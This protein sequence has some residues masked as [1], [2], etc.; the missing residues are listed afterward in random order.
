MWTLRM[1]WAISINQY[2][3]RKHKS[4]HSTNSF[5]WNTEFV[6]TVYHLTSESVSKIFSRN[7]N[8]GGRKTYDIY[9]HATLRHFVGFRYQQPNDVGG[10]RGF[11]PPYLPARNAISSAWHRLVTLLYYP[12]ALVIIPGRGRIIFLPFMSIY[13]VLWDSRTRFLRTYTLLPRKYFVMNKTVEQ[14]YKLACIA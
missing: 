1:R 2:S 5:K 13:C 12:S 8:A 10:R 7:I 9:L 4:F 3:V 14:H 11:N 6:Y